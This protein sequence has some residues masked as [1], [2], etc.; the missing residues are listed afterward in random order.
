MY[1]CICA[2]A[3][4]WLRAPFKFNQFRV[5]PATRIDKADGFLKGEFR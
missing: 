4:C 2:P 1:H 3:C 5:L